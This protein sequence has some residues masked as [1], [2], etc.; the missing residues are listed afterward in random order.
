MQLEYVIV[1]LV[2]AAV[3]ALSMVLHRTE[4]LVSTAGR[5][6]AAIACPRCGNAIGAAATL[7]EEARQVALRNFVAG[8]RGTLRYRIDPYWRLVCPSCDAALKFD[9]GVARNA[10]TLGDS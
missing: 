7:A 1:G 2:V 5:R 6:L 9:P 8:A 3:L 4:K 10:L